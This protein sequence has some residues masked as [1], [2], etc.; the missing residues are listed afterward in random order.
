MIP[1]S[2]PV[3]ET[4]QIAFPA[5]DSSREPVTTN[6]N[7]NTAREPVA[8]G[9]SSVIR[10]QAPN[11]NR[12]VIRELATRAANTSREQGNNIVRGHVNNNSKAQVNSVLLGAQLTRKPAPLPR[13]ERPRSDNTYLA[14]EDNTPLPDYNSGKTIFV[15]RVTVL[16]TIFSNALYCLQLDSISTYNFHKLFSALATD[17]WM[18]KN[19]HVVHQLL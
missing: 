4:R 6:G 3:Y 10:E 13:P 14:L 15:E 1:P 8:N 7:N 19:Q 12:D 5:G 17:V 11:G 16:I 18:L 2:A 9:N